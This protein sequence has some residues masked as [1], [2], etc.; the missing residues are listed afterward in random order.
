MPSPHTP[1]A[2]TAHTDADYQRL[3]LARRDVEQWED[4]ARTDGRPGGYEWWYF[5]AHLVDGTKMVVIFMTKD[6]STPQVP[7]TPTIRINLDLPDGRSL[8]KIA[9]FDAGTWSA[10]TDHADVRIGENHFTGDLHTYRISASVDDLSVEI[11]LVGEV[12]AW[13]PETGYM[14]FG[15][16][17]QLEFCWLPSVPK[18]H[19]KAKFS[20]GTEN[21]E[22]TGSGY[23][24]HNWGNVGIMAII[25]DWY[26]GRGQAGPYSAI[27]SYITA[28]EKY[29]Y[30]P[31]TVFML[32]KD[33]NLIADD[34]SLVTF[35]TLGSYTDSITKKPVA[36]ITRYTYVQGDERYVVT[37]SRHHDLVQSKMVDGLHGL[38]RVA[39]ELT[40][41]DGA[42]QRFTGEFRV[43]HYR[44]AEIIDQY[45]TEDAIWELMYF[46]RAR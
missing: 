2:V 37:F 26:W 30:T 10:A 23:H 17:R 38:K 45:A 32:A 36:N 33:G 43:E 27:A 9:S 7:L 46:G 12:S 3:G 40:R 31:I 21:H 29:D 19:V 14:L 41:F 28:N 15:A 16:D 35:E 34:T 24:D 11:E 25:N 20:V 22:S 5:D 13:R 42:Y 6:L 18:G 44:G 4:G 1:L 8:Q 39:A